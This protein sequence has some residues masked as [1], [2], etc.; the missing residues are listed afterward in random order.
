[1]CRLGNVSAVSQLYPCF[2]S[3]QCWT[4][5]ETM[6]TETTNTS[7]RTNTSGQL[8]GG[9][10]KH[11]MPRMSFK[12]AD[13]NSSIWHK[14][15]PTITI[16]KTNTF[17]NSIHSNIIWTTV[18]LTLSDLSILGNVYWNCRSD[19]IN[20]FLKIF[21]APIRPTRRH[22]VLLN[23]CTYLLTFIMQMISTK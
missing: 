20:V 12:T 13:T 7:D 2:V 4:C 16:T 23:L 17:P 19:S 10:P 5:A 8:H 6:P 18:V 11:L 14:L 9:I 3:S 15:T 21:Y 22:G 1:M